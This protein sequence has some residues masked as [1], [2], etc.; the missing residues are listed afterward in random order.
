MSSEGRRS[1]RFAFYASAEITELQ[2]AN[3]IDRSDERAESAWLLY[4]HGESV[5]AWHDRKD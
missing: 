1:P 3:A 2:N 5:A 4:G